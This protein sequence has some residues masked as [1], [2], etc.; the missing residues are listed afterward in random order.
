MKTPQYVLRSIDIHILNPE[1]S[2]NGVFC[3]PA[4][5]NNILTGI[6]VSSGEFSLDLNGTERGKSINGHL[7]LTHIPGKNDVPFGHLQ[8]E[9]AVGT[10]DSFIESVFKTSDGNSKYPCGQWLNVTRIQF[11]ILRGLDLNNTITLH[12][13]KLHLEDSSDPTPLK[14]PYN[15]IIKL[16]FLSPYV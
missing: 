11:A 4:Y 1:C 7:D 15:P 12:C 9:L 5:Y 6:S 16:D 3:I 10:E 8:Q 13:I 14:F 2:N